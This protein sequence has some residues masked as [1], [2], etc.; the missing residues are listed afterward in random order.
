MT[1]NERMKEYYKWLKENHYCRLC[2]SKDAYTL[3]GRTYCAEC[4]EKLNAKHKEN[5]WALLES[6]RQKARYET[7]KANGI[8]IR[9][10]KR[11][12]DKGYTMC[13]ICRA[14]LKIK[15]TEERRKKGIFARGEDGYCYRCNKGKAI[16]GKKLCEKCYNEWMKHIY[17]P[18]NENHKWKSFNDE[19]F[20]K[21]AVG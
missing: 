15:R 13:S 18:N 3:G 4:A 8:C 20:A 11:E 16:E 2:K 10:G 6:E 19:L 1:N 9:C 21:K 12:A 7:N 17:K 14:K 5:R